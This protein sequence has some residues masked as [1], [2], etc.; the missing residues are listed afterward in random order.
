[1]PDEVV[2]TSSG[3]EASQAA[4]RFVLEPALAAG[5]RPHLVLTDGEHDAS[6][7]MAQWLES[8]GGTVSWLPLGR[9]GAPR[10]DALE[11]LLRP[12]SRLV[13][14]IWVNN[15]T[16]VI[17]DVPGLARL[18]GPRGIPLHLDGAQAWGKIDLDLA[19][20]GAALASFSGHKIGG[21]AGTG[22]MWVGPGAGRAKVGGA[23]LM[24]GKQEAGRRGGTENLLGAIALGAAASDLSPAA[25]AAAV[26][27]LRD[28]FERELAAR[29]AGLRVHG[30]GAR[31]VGNTSSLGFEGVERDGLVMALDLAGF[32]VSPGSA[33]S[34][35]MTEPSRVLRAMGLTDAQAKAA[36]RVSLS[37][38]STWDE[39][40]AMIPALGSAVER[41]RKTAR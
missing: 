8:R 22:A 4:I 15:E 14:S 1:M 38:E 16:G 13:S 31:R 35:G 21:L 32:C 25:W 41:M 2:F 18:L 12:E 28:R 26:T 29:V 36:V 23:P 17:T 7:A 19:R 10:V 24:P 33:C 5:E 20:S 3:T 34:S 9:D 6:Y 27:P 30:A 40:E 37:T 11:G 39:L